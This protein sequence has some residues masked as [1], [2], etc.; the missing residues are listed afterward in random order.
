MS[1]VV[2]DTS[3]YSQFRAGHREI[4]ELIASSESVRLPA[5]VLGELEAGFALGSRAAD[6]RHLLEQFIAEPFVSVLDVT[7][8]VARRFG[9]LFAHLRRAGTPIP[10][11]DVWIAATAVDCGGHLVTFDHDFERV[12]GLSVTVFDAR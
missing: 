10:V 5:I 8:D 3:A 9:E 6:N 7:R 1:R 11:D 2:L 12:P 4:A